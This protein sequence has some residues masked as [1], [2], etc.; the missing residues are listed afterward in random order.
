MRPCPGAKTGLL[1]SRGAP[2]PPAPH[3]GIGA[4]RLRHQRGMSQQLGH[5]TSGPNV[6]QDR[7]LMMPC[8]YEPR[9][10][11]YEPD[12]MGPRGGWAKQGRATLTF[13]VK[14][15]KGLLHTN[16]AHND[17]Q[18]HITTPIGTPQP[19]RYCRRHQAPREGVGRV[20]RGG[21][22]LVGGRLVWCGVKGAGRGDCQEQ[23]PRP[24][25]RT[26]SPAPP[27]LAGPTHT[28]PSVL[29]RG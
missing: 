5:P 17:S 14:S 23:P 21:L 9:P 24:V 19:T 12:S 25:G 10:P 22:V 3:D 2:A 29:A 6:A 13:C 18:R 16:E 7:G 26:S 15:F 4:R 27:P 20:S 28:L 1:C 8:A 11:A